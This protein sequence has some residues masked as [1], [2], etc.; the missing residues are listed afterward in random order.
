MNLSLEGMMKARFYC[1]RKRLNSDKTIFLFLALCCLS[2]SGCRNK[3]GNFFASGTFEAVEVNVGSLVTGRLVRLD[4]REGETV[5][6]D[7]LLGLIDSE[8]LELERDLTRIRLEENDL[9]F[10]LLHKKVA[11]NKISLANDQKNLRRIESLHQEKSATGQQLDDLSTAL[12]LQETSLGASLKELEKPVIL[13]RE[14]ETNLKLLERN[15]TDTRIYSPLDGQIVARFAE[16]GEVVTTGQ[17]LLKV[18][19]LSLL[20]IRVYLPAVYLGRIKL[21]QEVSLRA[22]GAPERRI[23]GR[24]A[25]VS[26]VAEFT[27]KSVQTPENRAELVYAVKVEVQNPDGMLKVGMPADVYF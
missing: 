14:L 3:E 13:R 2:L 16:C 26:P 25:W 7:E 4:K 17:P 6:K 8:K 12:K 10:E 20:K 11:A 24:V 1:L 22:D 9:E 19:D 5:K 18:A 23:T 15:I 21:G 27:P